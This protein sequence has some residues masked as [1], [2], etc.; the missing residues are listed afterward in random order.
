MRV[1]LDTNVLI[2]ALGWPGGNEYKIVQSGFKKI[3]TLVLSPEILEEFKIVALRPKFEF[4]PE[5]IDEFI[6]ALL[7]VSDIVQPEEKFS[8]V[9]Q[10]PTDD[11][12]VD[13]AVAGK[14]SFIVSGDKHLLNLNEFKGIKIIRPAAFVEVL[15]GMK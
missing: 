11:K 14:A 10:D 6:S 1:V 13:A 2:S 3:L 9:L 12:I 7:E 15:S 4:S 8:V 5:E